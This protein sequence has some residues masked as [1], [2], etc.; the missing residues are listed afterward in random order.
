M[1]E[2]NC[3]LYSSRKILPSWQ[4]LICFRLIYDT[5]HI[6]IFNMVVKDI[7]YNSE[8]IHYFHKYVKIKKFRLKLILFAKKTLKNL[9]NSSLQYTKNLF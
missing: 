5:Y 4:T 6:L 3:L 8:Q 9:G 7:I 2:K 1:P